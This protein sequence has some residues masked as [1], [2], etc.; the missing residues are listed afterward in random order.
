MQSGRWGGLRQGQTMSPYGKQTESPRPPW[1]WGLGAGRQRPPSTSDPPPPLARF[2][3]QLVRPYGQASRGA[4]AGGLCGVSEGRNG[5]PEL[6][7]QSLLLT[8]PGTSL[9]QPDA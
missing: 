2:G 3:R 7:P 6:S 5:S 1:S 9:G 4:G 8:G